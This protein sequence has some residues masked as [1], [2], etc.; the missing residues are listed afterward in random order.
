[1]YWHFESKAHLFQAILDRIRSRW[2]E[3]VHQ[4]ISARHDPRERLAQL[5]DSYADLFHES[6][7]ICLFLQQILLD[8]HHR[9]FSAQVASVFSATA[10]FVAGIIDDGKRTG[11]MRRD[12]QARTTAHLILGVLAGAT[13]QAS[14]PGAPTLGR[15]L[16]AAKAMTLDFVS[17]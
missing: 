5:F 2:R 9:Q 6:P 13:Q 4:P 14:I 8:R 12:I 11:T 7:E 15:L 3:V 16:A 17:R 10:R 1:M